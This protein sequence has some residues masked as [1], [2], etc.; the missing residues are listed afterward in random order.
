MAA[1]KGISFLLKQGTAAAG[2]TLAGMRATS[3]TVN[4]ETVDVTNKDSAGART[5]LAA[6]GVQSLTVN[7]S[8]VF[9]DAVV[10]ETVRGYA[11][12]RS[13][14]AFGIVFE[15]GDKIDASWYISN[16]ERA[17]EY[18]GEETYSLTLESSGA[19]TY[20]AA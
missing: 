10:E 12:A 5:L 17:G 20:T 1:Q 13:I 7:A 11:F 4:N 18:N 14:N 6:A 2:T 8:G 15:N 16:Y 9:T 3:L 19:I